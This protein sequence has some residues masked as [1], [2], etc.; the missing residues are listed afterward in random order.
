MAISPTNASRCCSKYDFS[1]VAGATPLVGRDIDGIVRTPNGAFC[2][3]LMHKCILYLLVYENAYKV[4][5]Q[6]RRA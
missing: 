5:R 6:S 1:V 4:C 2:A 3:R